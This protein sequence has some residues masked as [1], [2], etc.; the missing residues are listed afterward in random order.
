[1]PLQPADGNTC[2]AQVKVIVV[3]PKG[4][5]AL[6]LRRG[7]VKTSVK[8]VLCWKSHHQVC[9]AYQR[10][11][12]ISWGSLCCSTQLMGMHF[13]LIYCGYWENK[14]GRWG[15]E[16]SWWLCCVAWI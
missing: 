5:A 3:K 11:L 10:Y 2:T 12:E 4:L 14:L 9:S 13:F 16:G 6:F 1:M 8:L 7:G 15:W